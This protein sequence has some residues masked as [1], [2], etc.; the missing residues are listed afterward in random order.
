MK[1]FKIHKNFPLH[2]LN[3]NIPLIESLLFKKYLVH[4]LHTLNYNYLQKVSIISSANRMVTYCL[5]FFCLQCYQLLV[6]WYMRG[7]VCLNTRFWWVVFF[8]F[9]SRFHASVSCFNNDINHIHC[10]FISFLLMVAEI[11]VV[12]VSFYFR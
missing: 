12:R 11:P 1:N 9:F 5:V 10:S 6:Y 4:R 8:I 3:P 2:Y 7:N